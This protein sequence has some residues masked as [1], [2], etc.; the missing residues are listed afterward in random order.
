MTKHIAED[1]T[2]TA[3]HNNQVLRAAG[4][5]P[6]C[7]LIHCTLRWM[8]GLSKEDVRANPCLC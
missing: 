8:E 7:Y 5:Q 3:L 1:K 6:D 4:M 2:E